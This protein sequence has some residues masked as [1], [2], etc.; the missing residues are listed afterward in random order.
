[1][2]R[3]SLGAAHRRVYKKR[4]AKENRGT[5]LNAEPSL[6]RQKIKINEKNIVRSGERKTVRNEMLKPVENMPSE[7]VTTLPT[8]QTGSIEKIPPV[9]S[10]ELKDSLRKAISHSLSS[11]NKSATSL[12]TILEKPDVNPKM[13][14]DAANALATTIQTQ[15]NLIKV[16]KSAAKALDS[17]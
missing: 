3:R 13:A 9:S 12:C 7:P 11:L 14:I 1:M 10:D 2:G 6:S 15:V 17:K 4:W 16:G 8:S 5:V